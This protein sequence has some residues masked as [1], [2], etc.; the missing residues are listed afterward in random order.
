MQKR[1]ILSAVCSL[2]LL[3]SST[4]FAG[5]N[6][7]KAAGYD[8][9][10][11]KTAKL[12]EVIVTDMSGINCLSLRKALD[13]AAWRQAHNLRGVTV[14]HN[15]NADCRILIEVN[16]FSKNF[17]WQPSTVT[18]EEKQDSSY[19]QVKRGDTIFTDTRI[20]RRIWTVPKIQ[21]GYIWFRYSVGVN[22]VVYDKTGQEIFR[23]SRTE[24]PNIRMEGYYK[25]MKKFF[26]KLYDTI[27]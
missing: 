1:V 13:F 20:T 2:L 15:D 21:R 11:I 18:A 9:K 26:E 23:Y 8:F 3:M 10:K 7:W 5:E 17:Y 22:A 16:D 4:A 27:N 14:T 19:E 25:I 12:E 24:E 6:V